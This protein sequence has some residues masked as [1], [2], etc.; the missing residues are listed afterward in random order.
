MAKAVF[1]TQCNVSVGTGHLK[2]CLVLAEELQLLNIAPLFWLVD[3]SPGRLLEQPGHSYKLLSLD[4]SLAS[5]QEITNTPDA[6]EYIIIV[7]CDIESLHGEG[8]QRSIIQKGAKLMYIAFSDRYYYEAHIIHNQNPRALEL[9]YKTAAHTQRLLG[10]DYVILDKAFDVA[11]KK[12]TP[13]PYEKPILITFGGSD[14]PGRTLFLLEVLDSIPLPGAH[15]IIVLGSLYKE[16]DRLLS[17][18]ETNF[19]YPHEL[20]IDTHKMAELMGKSK[21]AFTSG[22]LTAWELAVF[23]IP[24]AIISFSPRERISAEYLDRVRLA[25]HIG[26]FE[27]GHL[28]A[29]R[30]E[31]ITYMEH[32]DWQK[33]RTPNPL[34][35]INGK[36]RV[37]AEIAKLF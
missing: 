7:D 24:N 36:K 8:L 30:S 37:A 29:L 2:R 32:M 12:N 10:L 16:K 28:P 27:E 14:E 21:I 31:I 35:N 23:G 18:L 9:D 33:E 1:I 15:F 34:V 6:D 26:P 3:S 20:H 22:G 4:D 13:I 19:R 25:R 17:F 5:I 11:L